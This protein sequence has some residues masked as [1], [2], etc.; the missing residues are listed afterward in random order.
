MYLG[1]GGVSYALLRACRLP[2]KVREEQIEPRQAKS[3]EESKVEGS[4]A[5][6]AA[7]L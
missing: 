3:E 7:E 2:M 4:L 6:G 5:E 1:S